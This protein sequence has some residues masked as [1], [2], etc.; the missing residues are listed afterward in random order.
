MGKKNWL[1]IGIEETEIEYFKK[2]KL[3]LAVIS[4]Y[5]RPL[6]TCTSL[7]EFL[8]GLLDAIIGHRNLYLDAN[9]LHGDISESN[10]ILTTP[11]Q[12]GITRGK[13]IDL[14]MSLYVAGYNEAKS[15]TGTMKFMALKVLQSIALKE[16]TIVRTYRHDLESFFYVFLMGCVCY[17]R[18]SDSHDKHFIEWCSSIPSRNQGAKLLDIGMYFQARIIDNFSPHF[19]GIKEL[20]FELRNIIFGENALSF[21]TPRQSAVL[22]DPIITAFLKTLE[23][24]NNGIIRN[25]TWTLRA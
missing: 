11:A 3:T 12:N 14:D 13:L 23:K 21:D 5:G 8:S 25:K 15:I 17:G 24:I 4:P 20:A 19:N 1:S 2:R 6:K 18:D 22:Y 7:W 10:I 16:Y 9:I